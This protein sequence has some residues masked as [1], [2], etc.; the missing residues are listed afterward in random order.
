MP[1]W[2]P[3]KGPPLKDIVLYSDKMSDGWMCKP[4]KGDG[5]YQLTKKP[6]NINNGFPKELPLEESYVVI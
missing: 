2:E 3:S 6:L 5:F 4:A 1:V